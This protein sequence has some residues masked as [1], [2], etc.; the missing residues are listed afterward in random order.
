MQK[1]VAIV[2]GANRGIGLEICRQLAKH[3][4]VQVLLTSRNSSAGKQAASELRQSG[5][6]VHFLHLEV[7]DQNSIRR[8]A[9]EVAD[10]YG[11]ADILVN[12]AAVYLDS[13]LKVTE[14]DIGLMR[15]TLETNFYGP[16]RLCQTLIPLML[17]NQYGRIV[18][19]S[20]SMGALGT[21]RGGALAYRASKTALNA[22]TRVL[23][24]ELQGQNILVNSVDPGWVRSDMGGPQA[25]RTLAQG[26]DTALWLALLPDDGPS[27]GFFRDR[28]PIAW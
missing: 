7:T 1:K 23:A 14:I 27:G 4:D 13:G 19:L 24:S 11:R 9:K 18:N 21:M 2:T 25:R 10:R 8:L 20:S 12:N 6:D 22:L 3:E 5:G 26:A 17:R 16:L 15:Q 28:Q